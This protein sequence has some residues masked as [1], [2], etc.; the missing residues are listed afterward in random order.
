MVGESPCGKLAKD[1]ED[2]CNG[3]TDSTNLATAL[4]KNIGALFLVTLLFVGVETS[5]S[6]AFEAAGDAGS[7]GHNIA[8]WQPLSRLGIVS[9]PPIQ[10]SHFLYV[11][12]LHQLLIPVSPNQAARMVTL[13]LVG[14]SDRD[15]E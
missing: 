12:G 1:S 8:T 10:I 2:Q 3:K 14:E 15:G 9:D 7:A 11:P 5:T 4:C 6:G 13:Y